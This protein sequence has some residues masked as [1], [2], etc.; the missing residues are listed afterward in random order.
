MKTNNTDENKKIRHMIRKF[1]VIFAVLFVVTL[2]SSSEDVKDI[3]NF[4]GK[5]LSGA[6]LLFWIIVEICHLCEKYKKIHYS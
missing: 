6:Y 2:C 3:G 4:A 5:V 1:A